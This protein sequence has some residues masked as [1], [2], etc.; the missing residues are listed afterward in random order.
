MNKKLMTVSIAVAILFAGGCSF[1]QETVST[2][3][4]ESAKATS[5]VSDNTVS[6]AMGLQ[7][8]ESVET[9]SETIE[10]NGDIMVLFTSDVHCGVKDNF[11]Y[12]G[13]KKFR[14]YYESKGYET[15]LVDDGDA[16]QGD[17][18]G[19][20]SKGET[21]IDIMNAVGYD[22]AIPGNHE[23]DYGVDRFLELSQKADYH[24]I[25]CNFRKNKELL[26]EPY[27]IIEKAGKKIGFV[28]VTTPLTITSSTLKYF[29]NEQGEFIYDFMQDD[30]GK[31]VYDAIQEAVDAVRQ[32]GADYVYLI[33][34][35]GNEAECRPWTYADVISN[36][37]GIDVVLDGHSHDTDQIVMKN[38]N[39]EDVVRS[40]VGTKLNAFGYSQV[41]DKGI[42]KT[43]IITWNAGIPV[44]DVFEI[45]NDIEDL[46]N[47]KFEDHN[48]V[49]SAEIGE[50]DVDLTINDPVEKD[51]A[52]KPVRMIRRAETNMGD[53]AADAYRNQLGAE[54]GLAN[55][56]S[57]RSDLNRGKITFGGVFSITPYGNTICMIKA[58]GQNILDAL[59]YASRAVP[60][61][62]GGFMQV[63]GM[64]YEI[65]TYIDDPCILE[66]NGY[67]KEI[68]GERRVKNVMVGGEP[69]DP[70]R[71]YTVAGSDYTFLENGDGQT[72]FGDAEILEMSE[73]VDYQCLTDYLTE[74]L[75]GKIGDE[76]GDPYGQGR[77][78]IVEHK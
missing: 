45:D 39:G 67:L 61:E 60:G 33:S 34:H 64:S 29:K 66:E 54:I 26:F 24:Y 9:A 10:K 18:I 62:F 6:D 65:H 19:Y 49:L 57:I 78:V 27:T 4:S 20:F 42:A 7:T 74:T 47:T 5:S 69:I 28:G 23:F 51:T 3:S 41:T 43:D 72:A 11:G 76:Y 75:D 53:F 77:I 59:E 2:L 52:G 50:T 32:E 68:K 37:D 25:S 56:G 38:K 13:L 8:E 71:E 55:G 30:N 16:I 48:K 40:A 22:V 17:Y 21:I 12:A 44:T 63:S 46:V 31:M 36:T 58:K 14:D 73:L 35:L 70:D 1:S 15:I